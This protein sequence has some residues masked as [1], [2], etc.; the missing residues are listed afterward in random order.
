MTRLTLWSC[1]LVL[2]CG[3]SLTTSTRTWSLSIG[4]LDSWAKRAAAAAASRIGM[5]RIGSIL[6]HN[7]GNPLHQGVV[8]PESRRPARDESQVTSVFGH[9]QFDIGILRQGFEDTKR[10]ERVVFGLHE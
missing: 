8:Q 4:T 1:S 5:C 10:N 7:R 2:R 9:D 6:L 3:C